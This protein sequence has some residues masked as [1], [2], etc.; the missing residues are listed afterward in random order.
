L[1]ERYGDS[2]KPSID[3]DR[4]A[5]SKRVMATDQVEVMSEL[6]Y[7]RFYLVGHD[8]GA[9]IAHRLTLDYPESIKK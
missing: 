3:G 6:G 5:Y 1:C 8:R 9:R 4:A 2:S 7:D